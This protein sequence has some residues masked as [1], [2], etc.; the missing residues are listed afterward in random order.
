MRGL[1]ENKEAKARFSVLMPP[2]SSGLKKHSVR[3]ALIVESLS[4]A[5][6]W[7]QLPGWQ[8][9]VFIPNESDLRDTNALR[10][11]VLYNGLTG[12]IGVAFSLEHRSRTGQ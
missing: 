8:M 11:L 7:D 12:K 3:L 4:L 1:E 6:G 10:A 9:D 2:P 5:Y